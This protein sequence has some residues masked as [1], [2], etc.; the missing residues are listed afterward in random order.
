MKNRCEERKMARFF[1]F[2]LLVEG[3]HI[4]LGTIKKN[5]VKM[6]FFKK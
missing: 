1:C 2:G 6:L 3:G 4:I 5:I